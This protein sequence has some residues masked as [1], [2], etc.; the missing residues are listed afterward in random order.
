MV[1][2]FPFCFSY[3]RMCRIIEFLLAVFST[4][5]ILLYHKTASVHTT[6][7]PRSGTMVRNHGQPPFRVERK[8][9]AVCFAGESR[10]HPT[11]FE[12]Q[13]SNIYSNMIEPVRHSADIFVAI[14]ENSTLPFLTPYVTALLQPVSRFERSASDSY[15]KFNGHTACLDLIVT[16]ENA[17]NYKYK[18]VLRLRTDVVYNTRL[19]QSL[20][21]ISWQK[22]IAYAECCGTCSFPREPRR[23]TR[24][25]RCSATVDLAGNA[26]LST[27]CVKDSWQLVSRAAADF[28]FNATEYKKCRGAIQ[29]TECRSGCVLHMNHVEVFRI[30][31]QRV[32]LRPTHGNISFGPAQEVSTLRLA[33]AAD[34]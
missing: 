24:V 5:M 3:T 25:L 18:W 32:I 27:G 9:V 23:D 17:R 14:L 16:E 20:P 11:L 30:N 21:D 33:L 22:A 28:Y 8:T 1:E 31:M 13:I 6:L 12:A 34:T 7:E 10:R 15:D 2:R 29:N 4:H 19:P 26:R